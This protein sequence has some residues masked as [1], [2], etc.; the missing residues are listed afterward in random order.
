MAAMQ[1]TVPRV[2]STATQALR[3]VERDERPVS[4]TGPVAD[5]MRAAL[6]RPIA[7]LI[8]AQRVY[9]CLNGDLS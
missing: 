7:S 1:L 3:L 8:V 4:L 6:S 2:D 9:K 5:A